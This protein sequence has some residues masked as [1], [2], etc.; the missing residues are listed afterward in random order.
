VRNQIHHVLRAVRRLRVEGILVDGV[1]KTIQ[2]M[3]E[4]VPALLQGLRSSRPRTERDLRPDVDHG[5]LTAQGRSAGT[6]KLCA[7]N[8]QD[9]QSEYQYECSAHGP[10]PPFVVRQQNDQE[11]VRHLYFH[12]SG[13][14]IVA[15]LSSS[16]RSLPRTV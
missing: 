16:Q 1:A 2:L 4:V 7:G 11:P 8:E 10:S 14:T 6:G 3:N 12:F 13:K 9:R 15:D 5:I